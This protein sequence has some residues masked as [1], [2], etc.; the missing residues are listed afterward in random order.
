MS[1]IKLL[2]ENYRDFPS[3]ELAMREPNGLLAVGGDLDPQRLICA[4]RAG[5]F[6]WN[7]ENQP[8][9]W[10][11]PDPRCVL[12]PERLHVSRSLRKTLRQAKFTVSFDQAFVEVI[13][14][15]GDQRRKNEGTWITD[16]MKTAYTGLYEV[17]FGHSVEIW[18]GEQLVGGL[19]GIAMGSVFFGESMFSKTTDAS[20]V[21]LYYLVDKL[22][23]LGFTLID[24]QVYNPHL[25]SMGA[26]CIPRRRF[27][28]HLERHIAN[29]AKSL[30]Q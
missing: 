26:E 21:A 12:F 18:Q 9:L 6:P 3:V 28:E 1:E 25:E 11:S 7:E 30:W 5:I 2:N 14:A 24:C 22:Q 17:G 4:Y 15:C 23:Q 19:Y 27:I 29:P 16:A 10:W 20:K 8:L 13:N